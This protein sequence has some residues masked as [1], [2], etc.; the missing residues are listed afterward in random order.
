MDIRPAL[1]ANPQAA[2][3]REPRESALDYPPVAAEVLAA[4]NPAS[5]NAWDDGPLTALGP[6]VSGIVAFV[7]VQLG[8]TSPRTA[9]GALDRWDRIEH[10]GQR[11]GV[12][13]VR[14]AQAEREREAAPV[15]Q[16]MLLAARLAA[17]RRIRAGNFAPL[18]AGTSRLSRHAR[19]QSIWSAIPRRSSRTWCSRSQTP[20][21]CQSRSRRQQVTPLPQPSSRGSRSHGIPLRSTKRM[22]VSAARSGTRG[23]PPFGLGRSGGSSGAIRSHNSSL[24]RGL[25]MPLLHQAPGHSSWF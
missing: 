1:V 6:T 17:I 5:S 10:G 21:R 20:A 23:R 16:Q 2:E 9:Q 12:G 7:G 18:F 14:G 19:D 15:D 11:Q 22:P 4:L 13:A 3:A 24:T 25:L 8:G